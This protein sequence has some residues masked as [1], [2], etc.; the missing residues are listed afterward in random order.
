MSCG[1]CGGDCVT[2]CGCINPCSCPTQV[3]ADNEPLESALDNFIE[4][5]FGT[6]TKTVVNNEV[7]WVLPCNLDVGLPSNP[8]TAGEGL[9]CYF[10]RLFLNGIVG[11]VGPQG[12]QGP[13]GVD[14]APS[15]SFTS[16]AFLHP[17]VGATV[18]IPVTSTA[19]IVPGAWLVIAGSGYYQVSVVGANM[20]VLQLVQELSGHLVTVPISSLV[21]GAGPPGA[22]GPTG[23]TGATG[24]AGPGGSTGVAGPPG[25]TGAVGPAG[26]GLGGATNMIV[27]RGTASGTALGA[28]DT[29][30]WSWSIVALPS[31]SWGLCRILF[32]DVL[33]S[34]GAGAA[35]GIGTFK[36]KAGGLP[37]FDTEVYPTGTLWGGTDLANFVSPAVADNQLAVAVSFE[38]SLASF[39][40]DDP[41]LVNLYARQ[42]TGATTDTTGN[43][44][45]FLVVY[46]Y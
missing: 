40:S 9:A 6:V 11:L 25:A 15:W 32:Q 46:Y 8:R 12:P 35:Q 42:G 18:T 22:T 36:V 2:N 10:L 3:T 7:V 4:S 13:A 23:L 45:A 21:V 5:F 20:I 41:L 38:G 16:A 24:V 27:D 43:R 37:T 14:G 19:W 31:K 39:S 1:T 30:L 34:N 28:T 26:T 44:K 17:V 33:V 29:A